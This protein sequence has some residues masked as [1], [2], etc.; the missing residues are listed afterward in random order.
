[1]LD[2]SISPSIEAMVDREQSEVQR[3]LLVGEP[4][5]VHAS[6]GNAFHGAVSNGMSLSTEKERS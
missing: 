5:I 1:L 2:I 3:K 6:G 4:N